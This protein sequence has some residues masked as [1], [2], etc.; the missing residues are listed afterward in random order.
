MGERLSDRGMTRGTFYRV[1]HEKL[2]STL[3]GQSGVSDDKACSAVPPYPGLIPQL[4]LSLKCE[5]EEDIRSLILSCFFPLPHYLSVVEHVAQQEHSLRQLIQINF[6]M[7][8]P[9]GTEPTE[10]KRSSPLLC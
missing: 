5:G 10:E 2:L 7:L 4:L 9:V 8:I 3:T 1:S 6:L